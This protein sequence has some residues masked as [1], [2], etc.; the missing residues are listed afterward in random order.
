M[1]DTKNNDPAVQQIIDRVLAQHFG[2]NKNPER[3]SI[4]EMQDEML[5]EI[6]TRAKIVDFAKG[7]TCEFK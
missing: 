1:Q 5:R 4:G 2:I 6:H 3:K 7:E